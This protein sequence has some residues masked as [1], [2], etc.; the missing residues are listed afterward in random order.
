MPWTVRAGLLM[1]GV[2]VLWV[3]LSA[4]AAGGTIASLRTVTSPDGAVYR[5]SSCSDVT[6]SPPTRGMVH[7][8]SCM[9]DGDVVS[10]NSACAYEGHGFWLGLFWLASLAWGAD[11]IRNVVT[12]TVIGSVASWWYSADRDGS[13]VRGAL[14]RATHGSFG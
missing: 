5:A 10:Y 12:A 3:L 11:V 4:M 13:P 6:L 1:S 8:L 9:C 14:Y 7:H 2:Q